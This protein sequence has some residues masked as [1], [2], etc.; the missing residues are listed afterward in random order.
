MPAPLS[1]PFPILPQDTVHEDSMFKVDS[2]GKGEDGMGGSLSADNP[3][4]GIRATHGNCFRAVLRPLMVRGSSRGSCERLNS[5]PDAGR[6][7]VPQSSQ[8][9]GSELHFL[10]LGLLPLLLNSYVPISIFENQNQ[11]YIKK[12]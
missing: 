5:S 2:R 6:S 8:F 12:K 9:L 1:A 3:E 7:Q 4:D 11:S 10:T